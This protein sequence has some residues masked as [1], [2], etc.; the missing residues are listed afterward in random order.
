[1]VFFALERRDATLSADYGES[2]RLYPSDSELSMTRILARGSRTW[3][4]EEFLGAFRGHQ[5]F[6]LFPFNTLEGQAAPQN[7]FVSLL[8][9]NSNH[10]GSAVGLSCQIGIRSDQEIEN[11]GD[12]RR[13]IVVGVGAANHKRWMRRSKIHREVEKIPQTKRAT[14]IPIGPWYQGVVA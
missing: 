12:D 10:I 7:S 13:L 4:N 3:R 9:V 8:L 1:M 2:R 11:A 5:E 6:P 14:T